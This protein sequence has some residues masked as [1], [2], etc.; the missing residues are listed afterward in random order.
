MPKR[1]IWLLVPAALLLAGCA[2]IP[3]SYA[4]PMQRK[5]LTDPS[6]E[7]TGQ[8]IQMN[9]PDAPVHIVRDISPA[10][11]GNGWRWV[12]Q[13]PELKF[14]LTST[15]GLRFLMD[16]TVPEVTFK[17]TGPIQIAITINGHLLDTIHATKSGD[18]R[19]EKPVPS[20][21]LQIGTENHVVAEVDKF[22][23][24]PNGDVK[25]GFVLT[26]AGFIQ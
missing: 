12:Y 22:W 21:W 18:Q 4:P 16:Y 26:R 10:V 6:Q 19:F 25:L 20:E 5:P 17:D 14:T 9:A 3:D 1:R 15:E 13:R 8:F 7:S 23:L 11:E 24:P 2:R